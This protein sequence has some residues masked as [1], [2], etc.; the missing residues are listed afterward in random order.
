M[1]EGFNCR[2]WG[3]LKEKREKRE[4]GEEKEEE[5]GEFKKYTGPVIKPYQIWSTS[6]GGGTQK[7][8]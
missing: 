6:I 3:I 5:K 1:E 8:A 2:A 7:I 4:K